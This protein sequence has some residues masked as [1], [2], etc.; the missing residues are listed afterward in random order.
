M[1]KKP[2]STATREVRN[3]EIHPKF[4]KYLKEYAGLYKLGDLE[5][6]IQHCFISTN[7]KKGFLGGL[8]TNHTVVCF[9]TEFLF[10]GIMYDNK[11]SGIGAANWTEI[12]EIR[13]WETSEMSALMEAHGVEILCFMYQASRRSRSFIALDQSTA[14]QRCRELLKERITG[15]K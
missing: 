1:K 5:K 12:S 11:E 10:W 6:D 7:Q 9:T 4:I 14:G 2:Y 13:D 8:K 15:K 3:A